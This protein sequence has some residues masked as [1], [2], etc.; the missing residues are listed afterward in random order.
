MRAIAFI[1]AATAATLLVT[2][3]AASAASPAERETFELQC[4]GGRELVVDSGN[5]DFTRLGS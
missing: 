5:G 4:D 2:P 1:T 3:A